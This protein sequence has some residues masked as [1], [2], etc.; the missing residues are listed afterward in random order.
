[1]PDFIMD[2]SIWSDVSVNEIINTVNAI[3]LYRKVEDHETRM[4]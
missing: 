3:P 4:H 2:V 1:M